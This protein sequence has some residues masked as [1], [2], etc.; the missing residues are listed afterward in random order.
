MNNNIYFF[1]G[2]KAELIKI[3]MVMK[4]FSDKK[5]KFKIIASGQN[6][7][8]NSAPF[9]LLNIE[10]ADIILYDKK[11]KQSPVSLFLWFIKTLIKGLVVLRK[12]FKNLN[13]NKTF[14]IVH[15]DT[16]STV[17]GALIGKCYGL[18]VAHIEAGN[19][20]FNFFQPFPE[21]ID[22]IIVSYLTD[23]HFCPYTSVMENLKQRKGDKIN[24]S[25]NTIIDSWIFANSQN[26][27]SRLL[28]RLANKKYFIF[29]LHRQE[30]LYNENLVQMLV[31]LVLNFNNEFICI[32]IMHNSTQV[33]LKKLKLLDKI[34]K[35]TNI[36]ITPLLPFLEFM[37][38]LNGCEFIL[39]DGGSN[40]QETFYLGK[41]CLILRKV[42]DT[43]E[44][45]NENMVLSKNNPELIKDFVLNYKKYDRPMIT[46]DIS[47][48]KIIVDYLTKK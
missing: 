13:K 6:D 2:T 19:R 27:E 8:I 17:M 38:L 31:K 15:G 20:S 4:E 1:I 44:G 18:K 24:T 25:Y 33:T 16:V 11:I 21:E 43:A 23:V 35:K 28:R 14:M 5:V 48:S 36:I 7:I 32:F 45:M 42:N 22:R 46:P 34:K 29:I 40:Q 37:K 10:K 39:T 30:N 47:P 26:I 3:M 9:K 41:P 12:E